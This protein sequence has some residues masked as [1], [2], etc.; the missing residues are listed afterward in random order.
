MRRKRVQEKH[1][2]PLARRVLPMGR[3]AL[4]DGF[5][6]VLQTEG[7]Y[8][9]MNGH[10][11]AVQSI[12]VNEAEQE[13]EIQTLNTLYHCNFDSLLFEDPVINFV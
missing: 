3:Q 13:Y 5:R 2:A 7:F 6:A 12:T 4:Q 1:D 10:S 8:D 11:S 9:G